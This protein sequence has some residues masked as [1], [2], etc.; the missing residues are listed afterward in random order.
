MPPWSVVDVQVSPETRGGVE[1]SVDGRQGRLLQ[2]GES[3]RVGSAPVGWEVPCIA[4]PGRRRREGVAGLASVSEDVVSKVA[5]ENVG[6][7]EEPAGG[8]VED[9]NGL[10]GFNRGFRGRYVHVDED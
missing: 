2:A 7:E 9:L 8:W 3:V 1:L 5:E 4:R 6:G 10:L